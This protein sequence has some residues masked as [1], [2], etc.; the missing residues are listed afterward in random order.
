MEHGALAKVSGRVKVGVAAGRSED[1][2]K[3][4]RWRLI[5]VTDLPPVDT[6][7]PAMV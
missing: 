4:D 2:R 6:P 7:P 1:N 5:V 3:H